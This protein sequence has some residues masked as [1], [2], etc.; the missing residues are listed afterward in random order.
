MQGKCGHLKT[1][2]NKIP[3]SIRRHTG[4]DRGHVALWAKAK[5]GQLKTKVSKVAVSFRW[6]T[7]GDRGHVALWVKAKE[8][9][10]QEQTHY[11]H[12][13]N[14]TRRHTGVKVWV[15][16]KSNHLKITLNSQQ[17]GSDQ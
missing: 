3:F 1:K 6:S 13:P 14:T 8:N 7:G 5:S 17:H 4:G 9:K 12:N 10:Q 11:H 16:A 15:K 2:I